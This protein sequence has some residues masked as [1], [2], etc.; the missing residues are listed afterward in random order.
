MGSSFFDNNANWQLVTS[1]TKFI[2]YSPGTSPNPKFE[3]SK[4]ISYF[5]CFDASIR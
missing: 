4:Y 1:P 2:L 5:Q 3:Q